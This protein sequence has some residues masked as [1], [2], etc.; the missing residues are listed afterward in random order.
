MIIEVFSV[1]NILTS[2]SSSIR[3]DGGATSGLK[4]GTT[5]ELVIRCSWAI[6][7]G[8]FSTKLMSQLMTNYSDVK[9]VRSGDLAGGAKGL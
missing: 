8:M 6:I 9:A 3:H 4:G 5:V 2:T 1:L 7:P